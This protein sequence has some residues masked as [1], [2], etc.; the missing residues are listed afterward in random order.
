MEY[1]VNTAKS[2][3]QEGTNKAI[4]SF[5]DKLI[6]NV[7]SGGSPRVRH[8]HTQPFIILVLS[9]PHSRKSKQTVAMISL[10]S[11]STFKSP[12]LLILAAN[13]LGTIFISSS[14]QAS[15]SSESIFFSPLSAQYLRQT[16]GEGDVVVCSMPMYSHS[17]VRNEGETDLVPACAVQAWQVTDSPRFPLLLPMLTVQ[18]LNHYSIL[19]VATRGRT[20][21]SSANS[22]L[23]LWKALDSAG[24]TA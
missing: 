21:L 15:R 10:Q 24:L 9:V 8:G 12:S 16:E 4:C 5:H 13:T 3:G 14:R 7:F 22:I 23:S 1:I 2:S 6:I 18:P 11:P 20:V 19:V 17:P